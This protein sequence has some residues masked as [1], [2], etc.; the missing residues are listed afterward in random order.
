M[1]DKSATRVGCYL[2]DDKSVFSGV[3]DKMDTDYKL[4]KAI[5]T[6]FMFVQ[7]EQI[8]LTNPPDKKPTVFSCVPTVIL[9]MAEYVVTAWQIT[10]KFLPHFLR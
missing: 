9:V 1:V 8:V 5:H 6:N 10:M 4:N 2:S 7:P 3:F